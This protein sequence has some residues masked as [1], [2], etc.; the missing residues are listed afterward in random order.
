MSPGESGERTA[1][2]FRVR[3]RVQGSSST[4]TEQVTPE[5]TCEV[6]RLVGLETEQVMIDAWLM[7]A[8]SPGQPPLVEHVPRTPAAGPV[9]QDGGLA[10]H[11]AGEPQVPGETQSALELQTRDASFEQVRYCVG[12]DVLLQQ[13]ITF[14]FRLQT[15]TLSAT[16]LSKAILTRLPESNPVK[17]LISAIFRSVPA[18]FIPP[19]SKA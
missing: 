17:R 5:T 7:Q 3:V 18:S 14:W 9:P 10:G 12:S 16:Q 8:L 15:F 4:V 13:F 1:P 6:A 19:R 11:S 2:G